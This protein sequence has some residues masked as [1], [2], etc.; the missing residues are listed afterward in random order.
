MLADTPCGLGELS[1]LNTSTPDG[2]AV[3]TPTMATRRIEIIM[4]RLA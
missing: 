4:T 1:F 2:F 3:L